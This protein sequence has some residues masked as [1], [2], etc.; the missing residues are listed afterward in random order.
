LKALL[1][2]V[3]IL[4]LGTCSQPPPLLEQ[5]LASGE[6]RVATRNS[7]DAYYLGSHGPEGPAYELASRFAENL[8]VPLRLYTVRTREDA[9]NEVRAGR[10][11]LA[12]AGLSTGVELPPNTQFGPGYQLVR[13]HL[14][15]GAAARARPRSAR[16]R[17]ARSRSQQAALTSARCRNCGCRTRTSRGSS[18]RIRTPRRS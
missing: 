9:I 18:E 12:A 2:L 16:R 10:A 8:G 4:L 7:P 1:T 15:T 3:A 17:E 11:H 14:S 13:E 6:L 5:I